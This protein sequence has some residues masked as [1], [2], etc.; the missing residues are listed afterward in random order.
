MPFFSTII[1]VYNVAPYLRECLDSVLAQTFG[2]WEAICVDD[3]STDGSGAIL[4]EYAAKDSRFNV[5]HQANAGVSIA[6]NA[7]LNRATGDW[8][9]FVDGD[10][11]LAP[12][13]LHTISTLA[14]SGIDAV[15]FLF[16]TFQ[17]M[18][19][20]VFRVASKLADD[21][22]V[23]QRIEMCNFYVYLWQHVFP[24]KSIEGMLFPRYK[25]GEDRVFFNDYLLSRARMIRATDATLYGYRQ[26]ATSAVHAD[27]T[28]QVLLDE[29]D[30]RIDIIRMIDDSPKTVVYAG[31]SWLEG[32]F[33][34]GFPLIAGRRKGDRRALIAAWRERMRSLRSAKGF[35]R[36]GSILVRL[37]SRRA[38]FPLAWLLCYWLPRI[39]LSIRYRIGIVRR[40]LCERRERR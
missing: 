6:R 8:I 34:R 19:R 17:D 15:R 22:D 12:S 40:R 37:V 4:D 16:C 11:I 21:I 38:T 25:R 23:S 10:D 18:A 39:H 5:F 28:T 9:L 31:N 7:G 29:M 2:D 35:S 26:R 30:H 36:Q 3:G 24:R 14:V 20:P 33:T 13:S 32:Y 1:P 27:P